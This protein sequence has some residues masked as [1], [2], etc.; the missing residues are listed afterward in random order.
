MPRD[1]IIYIYI[2]IYIYSIINIDDHWEMGGEDPYDELCRILDQISLKY[3]ISKK[4]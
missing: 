2:Y 1:Y 3:Q 4:K